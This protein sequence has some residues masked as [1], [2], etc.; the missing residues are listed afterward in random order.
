M[1]YE[2][3]F[4]KPIQVADEADYINE[5]CY[6]GDIVSDVL[7][8]QIKERYRRVQANQEDW[9]WF[10]WFE[11]EFSKL[12]ID[13]FCD[14]PKSGAFRIHL[15][16]RTKRWLLLDKVIDTNELEALKTAITHILERWVGGPVRVQQL[17]D[18]YLPTGA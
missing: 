3:S 4:S 1:P 13:I 8:P 2:L 9:G 5:C 17:N 6:G 18:K 16:S 10:I 7:L 11:G 12:A 14:D 15:T